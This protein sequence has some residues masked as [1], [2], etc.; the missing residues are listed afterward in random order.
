L[1]NDETRAAFS[2]VNWK[3]EILE[4]DAAEYF[5]NLKG[6][7]SD[8]IIA[9]LFLHHLQD[10]QLKELFEHVTRATSLFI[11]CEPRRSKLALRFSHFLWVIG[12]NDATTLDTSTSVWAGF[13]NRELPA[14]WPAGTDWELGERFAWPFMQCFTARRT[15]IGSFT[16]R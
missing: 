12:R 7:S 15:G 3:L 4:A 1:V 2:A 14:L 11:A 8:A 13:R 6:P 9:N 16:N 10:E 5:R